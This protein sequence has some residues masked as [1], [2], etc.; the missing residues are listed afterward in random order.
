MADNTYRDDREHRA[1]A[2][3]EVGGVLF[4]RVKVVWGADNTCT[5]TS[6]ANP[7]PVTQPA[8]IAST[9]II[10]DVSLAA[11]ATTTNALLALHRIS[12]ADTNA[13]I[14]KNGAGRLYG[15]SLS[16]SSNG[17]RYVKF[18]NQTTTPTAGSGVV[19]TIG[20]P[21][22]G[23]RELLLDHGTFFSAGIGMTIVTEA[24]DAGTTGIG[25]GE[26][27]AEIFYA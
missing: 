7:L 18:H 2:A 13:A 26:V 9:A 4:Q 16:N 10:G 1:M 3:D 15:W 23:T 25:A 14:V 5:D 17:W 11:R 21:A 27:V 8:L 24:A 22:G 19:R 20:I 6:A 12:T